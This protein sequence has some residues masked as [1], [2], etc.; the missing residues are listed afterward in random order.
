MRKIVLKR[1]SYFCRRK[2][3]IRVVGIIQYQKPRTVL[4]DPVANGLEDIR[5]AVLGV[6]LWQGSSTDVLI[7]LIK[8]VH[9][10]CMDPENVSIRLKLSVPVASFNRNLGFPSWK[11]AV[12]AWVALPQ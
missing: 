9:G 11:L 2:E 1:L 6:N 5:F 10:A 3:Y 4:A 8:A 12:N 7:G